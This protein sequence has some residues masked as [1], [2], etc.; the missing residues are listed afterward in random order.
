[1][2]QTP[3]LKLLHRVPVAITARPPLSAM[4]LSTAFWVFVK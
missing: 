3:G 1:M 2:R 4:L